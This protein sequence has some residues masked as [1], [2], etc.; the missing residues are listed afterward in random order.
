MYNREEG[1]SRHYFIGFDNRGRATFLNELNNMHPDAVDASQLLTH[2]RVVMWKDGAESVYTV[3]RSVSESQVINK[4]QG[5]IYTHANYYGMNP[6][7][8]IFTYVRSRCRE[9]VGRPIC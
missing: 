3:F 8:N 5:C 1:T 7:P 6:T 9:K 4:T 2:N